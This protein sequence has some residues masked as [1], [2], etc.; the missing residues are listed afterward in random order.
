MPCGQKMKPKAP[1]GF[2]YKWLV[3]LVCLASCPG[4]LER[5]HLPEQVGAMPRD[6]QEV[7]HRTQ[8]HL[9]LG[10]YLL[11]TV[12][13]HLATLAAK[14]TSK[15]NLEICC[16][17]GAIIWPMG[18]QA[19]A[20]PDHCTHGHDLALLLHAGSGGPVLGGCVDHPHWFAFHC[21]VGGSSQRQSGL[22]PYRA[23]ARL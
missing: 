3:R 4:F 21:R 7:H 1:L 15:A 10:L 13:Q 17:P 19:I 23:L 12:C 18:L 11:T 22:D 14:P 8:G 20:D 9:Q 6:G 5:L 2:I 16:A